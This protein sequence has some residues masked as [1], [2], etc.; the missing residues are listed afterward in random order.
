LRGFEQNHQDERNMAIMFFWDAAQL[1]QVSPDGLLAAPDPT[2]LSADQ[3]EIVLL[4]LARHRNYQHQT[5]AAPSRDGFYLEMKNGIVRR[6]P[7]DGR[8]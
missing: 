2:P 5:V 3:V 7:R 4:Q 1:R 6:R 8:N